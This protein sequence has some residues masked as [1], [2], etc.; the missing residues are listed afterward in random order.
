M[1]WSKVQK[2]GSTCIK[3]SGFGS[4]IVIFKTIPNPI[5]DYSNKDKGRGVSPPMLS[6]CCPWLYT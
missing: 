1:A 5:G 6:W 2:L 3:A 4:G